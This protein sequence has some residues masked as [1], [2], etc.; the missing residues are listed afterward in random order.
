MDGNGRWA[1]QRGLPR[2]AG[3]EEGIERAREII[4]EC[5]RLGVEVLTLYVFSTENWRRPPEEVSFLMELL[6]DSLMDEVEKMHKRGA[7][8]RFL[9]LREG[10]NPQLTAKMRA[11][12]EK[13]AG[14]KGLCVNLAINYGGRAE[15]MEALRRAVAEH[16]ESLKAGFDE[17]LVEKYLFTAGQP[18]PDLVIRTS[19]EQRISNFLLWQIA[20]AELY[21]TP[22]LWPDFNRKELAKAIAE[23]QRRRRRFGGVESHESASAESKEK[24]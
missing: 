16:G 19:G 13:T 7:R 14:N 23:Y 11:A 3:H 17:S 9:G 24:K 1:K 2:T 15:L 6:E 4:E 20:Y 18:D 22:V 12:E 21:F 10:L 8:V 5:S